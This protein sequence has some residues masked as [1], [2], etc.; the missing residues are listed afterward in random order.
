TGTVGGIVS[1]GDNQELGANLTITVNWADG[2]TSVLTGL[3][4]GDTVVWHL[5]PNNESS[6]T[7]THAATASGPLNVFIQ[8][9]Y[10]LD[11]LATFQANKAAADFTVTNDSHIQLTD[12]STVNLNQTVPTVI[13]T[14]LSKK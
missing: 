12:A 13:E 3:R 2:K 11:F 4:A 1:M 5:G 7:I 14:T 10:P 6:A 8:R 9:T